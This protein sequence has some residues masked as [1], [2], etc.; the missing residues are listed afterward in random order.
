[1]Q[2]YSQEVGIGQSFPV[3]ADNNYAFGTNTPMTNNVHP[4]MCAVSPQ[5]RIIGC[6]SGH[7]SH[8][9]AMDA[10]RTHAGL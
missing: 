5:M 2:A 3:L 8:F 6:Y 10:V 7:G 1:M 4:E 9:D